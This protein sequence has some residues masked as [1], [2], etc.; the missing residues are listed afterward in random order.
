[1]I[2]FRINQWHATMWIRS[3]KRT[4]WLE[5]SCYGSFGNENYI[6]IM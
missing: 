3:T 5:S 4:K 6:S 1:M 2:S